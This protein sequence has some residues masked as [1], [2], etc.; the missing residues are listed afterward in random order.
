MP[1]SQQRQRLSKSKRR[2]I[3]RRRDAKAR[4]ACR[5]LHQNVGLLPDP[6]RSFFSLFSPSFT[7]PTFL[8]FA[9]LTVAAILTV[10]P[11]TV[12][13][14][15][16]TLGCLAPGDPSAYHRVFSSRRWSPWSL[17]RALAAWIFDSP[18][19]APS[20]SPPTTPSPNTPAIRSTARVAIGTPSEA[21][22]PSPPSAGDIS[23]WSSPSWFAS[24]GPAVLG[25]CP[26][27]SSSVGARRTT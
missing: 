3:R 9:L 23:G 14:L 27:S 25:L 15:L 2:E 7:R 18:A 11:S 17:G 16:R 8:R 13:N 20:S 22:T 1:S 5:Q 26:S 21:A 12:C 19:Q 4:L 10:G 24:P 6:F